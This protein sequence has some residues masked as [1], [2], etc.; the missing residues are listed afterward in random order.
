MTMNKR[1]GWLGGALA[2][3]ALLA[4]GW[5]FAPQPLSVEL[6]SAAPGPFEVTIDEDGRTRLPDRYVI[7]APLAGR[8]ARIN[9]RPGDA[10][11]AGAAV[12]TLAPA[13]A[14]LLDERTAREAQARVE[15]SQAL[16]QR[17]GARVARAE[18]GVQQARNELQRS[19][20][21]AR[22]GFVAATKLSTDE[23]AAAA[24]ARELEA[25]QQERHVAGHDVEQ[26]RAAL[27]VLRQPGAAPARVFE[28]RSPVAGQVLRVLQPSEGVVALG[29]PLLEVGQLDTLEVVVE[30]LTTDAPRAAP[31]TPVRLERWGG[32]GVLE[33]RVKRVEPAAFTKVSALGVEE[34]RVNLVVDISTP[35][36]R[37][38]ALGDGFRISA[39][40]VVTALNEALLVPSSAVFPLPG[41]SDARM[42]VFVAEGG[43]AR[44]VPVTLGGRNTTVA[45]VTEG[46]AA[47]A[48]V[49]VF[50]PAAVR[51]GARVRQRPS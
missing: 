5:A 13:L 14:P 1:R 45:W 23:L 37:W 17:A 2:A 20:Q 50:P 49:I 7:S 35:R 48:H 51:D 19:E 25:A 47:G 31:G 39:R 46:L 15:A 42:A 27:G 21:L 30:L 34:Q 43:R 33:G 26:A 24:A 38:R 9:L 44:L 40:I 41:A 29:A 36:E 3:A 18:V 6:A 22:Q 12:A 4:L 32:Q 10:V 11:A 16:L 8:L 28:V